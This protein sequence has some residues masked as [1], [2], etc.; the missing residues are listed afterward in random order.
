MDLPSLLRTLDFDRLAAGVECPERGARSRPADFREVEGLPTSLVLGRQIFAMKRGR[1][2]IPHGHDDMATGFLVLR[3]DFR[4]RH[5]DRA[6][7]H[8]D[9]YLIRPTIDR[10]FAPGEFSTISDHKDNVPWFTVESE[11][12]F[13]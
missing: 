8:D 7:D 12:G 9:H 10:A 13:P 6:E 3:G 2:V 1:S 5:W 11:T 4:G